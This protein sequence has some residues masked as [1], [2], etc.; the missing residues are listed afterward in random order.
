MHEFL[1]DFS[2]FSCFIS[3]N[4]I[5]KV[6]LKY[7]VLML[8]YPKVHFRITRTVNPLSQ[9]YIYHSKISKISFGIFHCHRGFFMTS[10]FIAFK[11]DEC[12]HFV[13]GIGSL[14][15]I[16]FY[17]VWHFFLFLSFFLL[18]CLL[19]LTFST[20]LWSGLLAEVCR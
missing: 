17:W 2:K 9:L 12:C 5:S 8:T 20:F 6:I 7:L 18:F 1:L 16:S 11:S 13:V 10:L 19:F 14:A 15:L 4:T 3:K